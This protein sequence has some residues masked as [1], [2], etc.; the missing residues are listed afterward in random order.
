MNPVQLVA[1][2]LWR[3][4]W[5][6]YRTTLRG[7]APKTEEASLV[8]T[9]IAYASAHAVVEQYARH[10]IP[11]QITARRLRHDV[12][13]ALSIAVWGNNPVTPDAEPERFEISE[14]QFR[15]MNVA[16]SLPC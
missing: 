15:L 5:R 9:E 12:W 16:N 8:A 2:E 13:A 10:L 3:T 1:R 11:G 6:Q 7:F 4:G 14:R